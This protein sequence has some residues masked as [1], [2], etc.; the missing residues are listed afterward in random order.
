LEEPKMR[1]TTNRQKDVAGMLRR[2]QK[3][4][5][6]SGH[7]Q[8]PLAPPRKGNPEFPKKNKENQN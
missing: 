5:P 4:K 1:G 8:R 3:Q 7:Q 6:L 2:R